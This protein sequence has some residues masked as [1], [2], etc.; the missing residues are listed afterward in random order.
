MLSPPLGQVFVIAKKALITLNC[1]KMT[2]L[3]VK[4]DK[5]WCWLDYL[6]PSWQRK[7]TWNKQ[8]KLSEVPSVEPNLWPYQ[9]FQRTMLILM[10]MLSLIQNVDLFFEKSNKN[11]C[12]ISSREILPDIVWYLYNNNVV[13]SVTCWLPMSAGPVSG[14]GLDLRSSSLTS[15]S[16]LLTYLKVRYLDI[17]W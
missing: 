13:P 16:D 11:H 1:R 15:L 4:C 2:E 9:A 6:L 7:L 14:K 8:T 12:D 17:S 3:F 5:V 10:L